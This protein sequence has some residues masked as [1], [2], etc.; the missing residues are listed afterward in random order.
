MHIEVAGSQTTQF[1]L[2][3]D[4]PG[5]DAEQTT[6]AFDPFYDQGTGHGP[7]ARDQPTRD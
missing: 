2:T 5:L 3:D 1:A 6:Q 4:G 7:Q